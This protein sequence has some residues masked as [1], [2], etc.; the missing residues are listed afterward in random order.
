MIKKS[1]WAWKF[2]YEGG[3]P[4]GLR[5]GV[6]TG[7]AST[8][9]VSVVINTTVNFSNTTHVHEY[10]FILQMWEKLHRYHEDNQ[11]VWCILMYIIIILKKCTCSTSNNTLEVA[12]LW[13]TVIFM[14]KFT[15]R[16][17]KSDTT[18]HLWPEHQVYRPVCRPDGWST[19]QTVDLMAG[20]QTLQPSV[21]T[22]QYQI[23]G[24]VVG[25]LTSLQ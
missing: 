4:N 16:K 6:K 17:N 22:N 8:D 14:L 10:V 5:N 23:N 15:V 21:I 25:L 3:T 9:T 11:Y 1:Q 7:A 24:S 20:L 2:L 13:V 12:D 19:D 18:S